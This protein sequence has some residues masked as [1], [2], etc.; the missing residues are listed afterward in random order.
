MKSKRSNLKLVH[1]RVNEGAQGH[2]VARVGEAKHERK[3]GRHYGHQTFDPLAWDIRRVMRT[4]Q[5]E[6][7]EGT[8]L[9]GQQGGGG[10][11]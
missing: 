1:P 9:Y 7:V 2:Y 11:K 8:E 5:Y 10:V 4:V 3:S 6:V